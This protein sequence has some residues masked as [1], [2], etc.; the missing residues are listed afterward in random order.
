MILVSAC[1]LGVDCKYSGKSNDSE[2]VRD[3][4]KGKIFVPVCPEQLGGLPT[5]RPTCEIVG[6]RVINEH[7]EDCT[8][9]FVKGAEEVVKIAELL[10]VNEAL[11]KEGSPSCGCNRIYDGTFSGSKIAG[12]GLTAKMLKSRGILVMSDEEL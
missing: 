4:L 12:A 2:A 5:P 8:M 10:N 11:L 3:Y 7:G 9:Q 6:D 1:L